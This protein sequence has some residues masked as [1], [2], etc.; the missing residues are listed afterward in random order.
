MST[1]VAAVVVKQRRSDGVDDR[2]VSKNGGAGSLHPARDS[3][4]GWPALCLPRHSG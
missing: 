3:D 4:R 2:Y 1:V